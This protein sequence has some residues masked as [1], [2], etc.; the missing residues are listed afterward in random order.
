MEDGWRLEVKLAS[1]V[2]EAAAANQRAR[3]FQGNQIASRLPF[4]TLRRIIE[5]RLVPS[6][7]TCPQRQ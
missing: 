1:R 3:A 5:S 2:S 7:T 6:A 4:K